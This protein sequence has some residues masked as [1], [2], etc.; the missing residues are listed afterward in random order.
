MI[1]FQTKL[2]L[3]QC[4]LMRSLQKFFLIPFKFSYNFINK[5][6]FSMPWGHAISSRFSFPSLKITIGPSNDGTIV[7]SSNRIMARIFGFQVGL[8]SKKGP[9]LSLVGW[10]G[11]RVSFWLPLVGPQVQEFSSN[12]GH[13]AALFWSVNCQ[14]FKVEKI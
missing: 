1:F 13:L 10:V 7:P 3:L 2:F 8:I 6:E 11:P 14:V 4:T 9:K 5:K 12:K